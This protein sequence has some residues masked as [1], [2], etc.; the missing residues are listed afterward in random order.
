MW[1]EAMIWA[2]APTT[3]ASKRAR[4]FGLGVGR[5]KEN[6]HVCTVELKMTAD[7]EDGKCC[8]AYRPKAEHQ[9]KPVA[10]LD[11]RT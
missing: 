2:S 9:E 7:G 1:G 11:F 4:A 5:M 3:M 8:E 10:L 6:S